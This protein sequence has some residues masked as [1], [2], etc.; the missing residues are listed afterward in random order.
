[1]SQPTTEPANEDV[2][3]F[4]QIL[5]AGVDAGCS[6]VHI[7]VG[8]PASYRISRAFHS[9][10]FVPTQVWMQSVIDGICPKHMKAGLEAD[11]RLMLERVAGCHPLP[12]TR[13]RGYAMAAGLL[14]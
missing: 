2:A 13:R 11:A 1:M 14:D 8:T 5:K 4:N 9:I 6:D 12:P 7:K 10:D 3:Y